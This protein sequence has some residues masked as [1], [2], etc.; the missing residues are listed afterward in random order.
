MRKFI[1]KKSLGFIASLM[2]MTV[3]FAVPVLAG[4]IDLTDKDSGNKVG[5]IRIYD[6]DVTPAFSVDIGDQNY[7]LRLR[8]N[9]TRAEWD[10]R[11]TSIRITGTY[12]SLDPNLAWWREKLVKIDTADNGSITK[13]FHSN[14]IRPEQGTSADMGVV[15]GDITSISSSSIPS[16]LVGESFRFKL[17]AG[18]IIVIAPDA[19]GHWPVKSNGDQIGWVSYSNEEEGGHWVSQGQRCALSDIALGDGTGS[20]SGFISLPN[21][22]PSKKTEEKK[23]EKHEEEAPQ[24]KKSEWR[25]APEAAK[26]PA[27]TAAAQLT[28][29]QTNL[30]ALSVIP[31]ASKEVFKSSGM[32]LNMTSVNTVDSNTTKLISANSDIPYNVTFNFMG[33]PM[34]CTIPAGF[35]YAQFTKADGTMNIHEVLWSV[36]TGSWKKT[37]TRAR[38][39][40]GRR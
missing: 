40:R 24:P 20:I 30:A 35:N 17:N 4:T 7:T 29:A 11:T 26:T 1:S 27:Q 3:A 37:N 38:T 14:L 34:I 36:Y 2:I 15:W 18:S 32:P 6:E 5:E 19:D 23:E 25:P 16:S 33:K 8:V 22:R 21:L 10:N 13:S 9:I 28:T 31:A 12:S 39:T